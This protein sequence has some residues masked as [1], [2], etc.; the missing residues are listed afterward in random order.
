LWGEPLLQL[1]Q[2]NAAWMSNPDLYIQ[3]V[4]GG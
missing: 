1:A 2:A 3:A 4:I